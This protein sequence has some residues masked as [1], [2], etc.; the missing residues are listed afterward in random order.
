MSL[1]WR[2]CYWCHTSL[3]T[4]AKP[5]RNIP[6]LANINIQQ[7]AKHTSDSTALLSAQTP[8]FTCVYLEECVIG[9]LQLDAV[10]SQLVRERL[11]RM[12]LLTPGAFHQLTHTHTH[13]HASLLC[14]HALKGFCAQSAGFCVR[15]I[16][17]LSESVWDG[18][19]EDNLTRLS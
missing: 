4:V 15:V 14:F 2:A 12:L 5:S 9:W 11:W 18:V 16:I 17:G 10:I 19:L 13:T 6:K 7:I 3:I 8:W 1:Q